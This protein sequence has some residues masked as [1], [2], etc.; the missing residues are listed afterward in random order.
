MTDN[1]K[2]D[3]SKKFDLVEFNKQFEVS[4]A[5]SDQKRIQ[6]ENKILEKLNTIPPPPSIYEQ[7]VLDIVVGIK[8]SLF[9]ILDDILRLEYHP[10]VLLRDRRLFYFGVL[11]LLIA[12][13]FIIYRGLFRKDKII[14]R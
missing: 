13:C 9:G 2:T 8:D 11:I 12:L 3:N 4:L 10:T 14:R 7:S 1:S 5:E 6:S